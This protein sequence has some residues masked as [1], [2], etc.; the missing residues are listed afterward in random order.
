MRVFICA[1]VGLLSFSSGL[2]QAQAKT[3][4][5]SDIDDTIKN[6]HI[7]D[8]SDALFNAEKTENLVLGMNAAYKAVKIKDA[9]IKFFYVTNAPKFLMESFHRKFLSFNKF[10]VGAVRLR[11]NLFQSDFKISEI[12]KILK[13]EK[14]NTVILTGD[15]GE[16]DIFVYEQMKM[17]YPQIRFFTYIHQLYSRRSQEYRGAVIRPGQ[18]GFVTSLDLILQ[19]RKDGLVASSDV[20][21]FV[22]SFATDFAKEDDMDED[23]AVAIPI[24]LDCRDF[25]WT[26]P[27]SDLLLSLTYLEAKNRIL[28]RCQIEPEQY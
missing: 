16:K 27:D 6:S 23:G 1:F 25:T 11:E 20:A 3:I 19:L 12:R 21:A 24:W 5:I 7:L 15:N 8:T 26:A 18:V 17:E 2:V 4:L 14:P 28:E 22:N 9:S 10:P 13:A